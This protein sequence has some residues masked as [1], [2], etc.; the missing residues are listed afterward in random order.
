MTCYKPS[1]RSHF[2]LIQL[3]LLGATSLSPYGALAQSA[4]VDVPPP[5]F[6]AETDQ[7]VNVATGT[8]SKSFVDASVGS[9]T[10]FPSK[11]DFVRTAVQ[12]GGSFGTMFRHN[13]TY[14]MRRDLQ[15]NGVY[16]YTFVI[17]DKTYHTYNNDLTHQ[18]ANYSTVGLEFSSTPYGN[19]VVANCPSSGQI[20]FTEADG[21]KVVF[22]AAAQY[23]ISCYS[24]VAKYIQ[25]P[26]GD[27]AVLDYSGSEADPLGP[28]LAKVTN[29]HGDSLTL[30]FNTDRSVSQVTA[31]SSC[32]TSTNVNCTVGDFASTTYGYTNYTFYN[33]YYSYACSCYLQASR[34]AP[35]LT[36]STDQNGRTTTYG[37]TVSSHPG[38]YAYHSGD[39]VVD[40]SSVRS[41]AQPSANSFSVGYA[42]YRD[43]AHDSQVDDAETNY[44]RNRVVSYTDG[45]GKTTLYDYVKTSETTGVTGSTAYYNT[46]ETTVTDPLAHV[47]TFHAEDVLGLL[48]WGQRQSGARTKY[49]YDDYQHMVRSTDPAGAVTQLSYDPRGN[50]TELRRKA[51][52][53]FSASDIV[54]S[55]SGFAA[56][57]D[58]TNYLVCNKPSWV[59]TPR[60]RFDYQYDPVHGGIT[61]ELA[62]AD[63]DN[64][65][66][67]TRFGY[68]SY[69][70]A[71]GVTVPSDIATQSAYRETTED[72]CLSSGV[73]GTSVDFSYTCPLSD[74]VR[75]SY[76]Y[77]ASTSSNPTGGEL[78]SK[79]IDPS[80]LALT[81]SY[82]WD[83]VGNKVSEDGPQTGSND[84][85]A[86]GYDARR[87]V[88]Q[89]TYPTLNDVTPITQY[90]YD[91]NGR[92][93]QTK[94]SVAGGWASELVDYDPA[95]QITARTGFDGVSE[96]YNYYDDGR[97]K[98]TT[99]SV[100]SVARVTRQIYDADG[101]LTQ[102]RK[103]VGVPGLE[104]AYATWTYSATDQKLSETDAN[105]NVTTMCYDGFDRLAEMRFPANGSTPGAAPL[106]S[107][108]GIGAV[109]PSGVT[110]ESYGYDAS[111]NVV[112]LT[113]RDGTPIAMSY[114]ALNRMIVKDVPE[115]DGDVNYFYDLTGRRTAATLSG[116]N[117]G[118]SV[119]WTY[120]AAG[121]QKSETSAGR[122]MSRNYDAGSTYANLVW[123]DATTVRETVDAMGRVTGVQDV[124][125]AVTLASYDY[126]SLSRKKAITRANGAGTSLSYDTQQRLASMGHAITGGPVT[127]NYTYNE[128]GQVKTASQSNDLYAWNNHFNVSRPY[129]VNALNQYVAIDGGGLSYDL[130]GNL[131]GDGGRTFGYDSDNRLVSATG[132]SVNV[133]LAYDATGRLA[134]LTSGGA[135]TQFLYDGQNLVGEYDGSGALVRRHVFGSDS[136][137]PIVTIENGSRT[138]LHGDHE[139]SIVA[140]SGSSGALNAVNSYDEYG[141]PGSENV[142]RFQYT[143]QAWLSELGLYYYKARIYSPKL[144]RFLQTD[145]VG[146]ADQLNLY[147]YV[148]NDPVNHTDPTGDYQRGDGFTDDQ[149]K[150]FDK[151]QQG[152]AKDMNNRAGKL[153]ASAAKRDA[154][155][156]SGGDRMRTEATNLRNGTAALSASGPGA[157][158]ANLL[159]DS[160]FASARDGDVGCTGCSAK[161][162]SAAYTLRSGAAT[163]FK[164]GA[165]GIFDLSSAASARWIIGH[166]SMHTTLGGGLR[167]R[168]GPNGLPGYRYGLPGN[169]DAYNALKGTDVGA[170]SPDNL[171]GEVYP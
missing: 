100:D 114:D 37:Y 164:N 141:N 80:G 4:R 92:R 103:A 107:V 58:A 105:G 125:G 162:N 30:S 101:R 54:T 145:P 154:A 5:T 116:A 3:L 33:A 32:S 7:G 142:G 155:G 134:R 89:V 64:K 68:T 115:A 14:F 44:K 34:V 167:D 73:T 11:L 27:F 21:T 19:G 98:D 160:A 18:G 88:T 46:I 70:P 57:C 82:T 13:L 75:M 151:A 76:N 55:A 133:V 158:R 28:Q 161:S 146:T 25:A 106:C 53:G 132:G 26:N 169:V 45:A 127:W 148:G 59:Q 86:F 113:K 139:G 61:V 94:R 83:K 78:M 66:A 74:L 140:T 152:A 49:E 120:D 99:R 112:A 128:A 81:T 85:V 12:F 121:R 117:A 72:K 122:T 69:Y 50:L 17:G 79:V 168:L 102:V 157:P 63:Q 156:K 111:G 35:V 62:P 22:E 41:P 108:T 170:Q 131:I 65:R 87:N 159:S 144:G 2:R 130:R 51:A 95:D 1:S 123:P 143:G 6:K 147:A 42:F 31:S 137:E 119:A 67:V 60:G 166:D 23:R 20:V 153:D 10:S 150:Q 40:L 110:R 124:T 56:T 163:L 118:L 38:D 136:D 77:R 39:T 36:S 48:Y 84:T 43:E 90:V 16:E 71:A 93:T 47:Q 149:W 129:T 97:L 109:L 171:M 9:G 8:L 126:D 165:Q 15:G 96:T 138:W 135:V 104:Q 91:D 24:F 29:N 52:T